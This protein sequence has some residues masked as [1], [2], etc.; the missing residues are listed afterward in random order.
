M[1]L[2][3]NFRDD[4]PL[5]L[6]QVELADVFA[7]AADRQLA[8]LVNVQLVAHRIFDRDREN[9]RLQT[10]AV[11]GV[12]RDRVMNARMRLRVNSLSVSS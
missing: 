9:F 7:A 5:L 2:A 11:A 1:D 6:G 3:N 4:E 12:A 8:E 10:S